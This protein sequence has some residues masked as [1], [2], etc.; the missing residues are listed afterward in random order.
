MGLTLLNAI[1][2]NI[3][4]LEKLLLKR[5]TNHP[6]H[7]VD[8]FGNFSPSAFI[9]FCSFGEDKELMG[10]NIKGFFTPVCTSFKA[11]VLD[12]QLCYEV[13]LQYYKENMTNIREQLKTGLVLVLNINKDRQS[14]L[15]EQ[16]NR[17]LPNYEHDKI[18]FYLDS[19]GKE[20]ILFNCIHFFIF[21]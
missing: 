1:S 13:D 5:V 3:S 9:P 7:I 11:K 20:R 2:S 14:E 19:I 21:S 8:E 17:K 10:K 12:D 18:R 6:V 16:Q 15:H 4:F